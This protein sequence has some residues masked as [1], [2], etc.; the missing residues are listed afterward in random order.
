MQKYF[1]LTLYEMFENI[2]NLHNTISMHY[3]I[4]I[5]FK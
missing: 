4:T 3:N 5:E 2:L 1:T